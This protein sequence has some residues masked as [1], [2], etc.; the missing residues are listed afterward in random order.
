MC[1]IC[2]CV[3][4][5]REALL[6]VFGLSSLGS[7]KNR[8]SLG[9]YH[10]MTP[11]ASAESSQFGPFLRVGP[12]VLPSKKDPRPF[13][14]PVAMTISLGGTE[15]TQRGN[16]SHLSVS[17]CIYP[18]L[19]SCSNPF[20]ANPC[21]FSAFSIR[22]SFFRFVCRKIYKQISAHLQMWKLRQCFDK[23]S[24]CCMQ[25]RREQ[26]GDSFINTSCVE[27]CWPYAKV[28]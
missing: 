5:G 7:H 17:L 13:L 28:Y 15:W 18:F 25:W 3:G 20:P 10:D 4:V 23:K 8:P 2:V 27:A 24:A 19:L 9:F 22:F 14:S 12:P 21:P 1:A 11:K 16:S 6:R 26:Q